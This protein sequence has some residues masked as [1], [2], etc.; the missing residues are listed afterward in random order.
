MKEDNLISLK[1]QDI[2]LKNVYDS[3]NTMG[4]IVNTPIEEDIFY[5][6]H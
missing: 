2:Y 1:E 5:L 4:N 3:L 6:E